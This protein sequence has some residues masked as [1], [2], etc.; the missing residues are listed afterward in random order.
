MVTKPI[1]VF[2]DQEK[3]F[4]VYVYAS[5]ISHGENMAQPRARELVHPIAFASRKLS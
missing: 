5:S 3:T 1:L 2:P 4:H